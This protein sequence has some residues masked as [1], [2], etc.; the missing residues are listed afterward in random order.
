MVMST[1]LGNQEKHYIKKYLKGENLFN[2]NLDNKSL[3]ILYFLDVFNINLNNIGLINPFTK[4]PIT[5]EN[6]FDELN[7]QDYR[8][9]EKVSKIYNDNENNEY[10][11][12][13]IERIAKDYKMTILPY[14]MIN[15]ANVKR[16]I[17][18]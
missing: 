11:G 14:P 7:L 4:K 3:I 2:K 5:L 10:L 16:L 8:L 17:K 15:G 12:E 18:K 6:V 9:Y 13:D 1:S